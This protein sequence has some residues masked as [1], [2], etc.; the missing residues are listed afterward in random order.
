LF[1]NNRALSGG[2]AI[3][4][5][6]ASITRLNSCKFTNNLEGAIYSIYSDMKIIIATNCVFSNNSKMSGSA[7]SLRNTHLTITNCF[8]YENKSSHPSID[9]LIFR[10]CV[11]ELLNCTTLI[12]K[13]VFYN[14]LSN[15]GISS[16]IDFQIGFLYVINSSFI[17]NIIDNNGIAY[18][19]YDVPFDDNSFVE[20]SK[21]RYFGT[22][23]QLIAGILLLAIA[24]PV[25]GSM[26]Y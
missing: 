21:E 1:D 24:I 13:S 15:N 25:V 7:L 14:N 8:F 10:P 9:A 6:K 19:K 12:E 23:T 5:D 16:V 4:L 20:T 17:N 18:Y 22:G 2:G 3:F 11:L 26:E